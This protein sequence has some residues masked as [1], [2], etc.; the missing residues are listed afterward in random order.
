MDTLGRRWTI[1]INYLAAG[2]FFLLLQVCG[3]E[4]LLT[5][6]M[7]G[8]RAFTAGIFNIVYIYA[9]EVSTWKYGFLRDR[10]FRD[11]EINSLAPVTFEQNFR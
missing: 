1:S 9:T 3:G 8:V 2:L 11:R 6:F 7:F 10:V 5:I 4:T